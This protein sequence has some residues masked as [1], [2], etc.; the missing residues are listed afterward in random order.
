MTRPRPVTLIGLALVAVAFV[1]LAAMTLQSALVYDLSPTELGARPLGERA[2]LYGIVVD[3]TARYDQATRTL[4]FSVTDGRTT[5][6]VSTKSIPTALFR[7]G[8][9][10]VLAGRLTE[11]G[12]FTADELIIKHS[13]VYAPLAPGQTMPPGILDGSDAQP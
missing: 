5:T 8:T 13:E 6:T 4:H 10:V 12:H 3:D 2:R 11:P 1:A 9:A 7:D